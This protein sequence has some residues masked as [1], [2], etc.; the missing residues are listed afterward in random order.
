MKKFWLCWC[1]DRGIPKKKHDTKEA[2]IEEAS[3][4]AQKEKDVVSI[5]ECIGSVEP[6]IVPVEFKPCEETESV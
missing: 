4:V 5:L 6:V 1:M 3:R 2:A